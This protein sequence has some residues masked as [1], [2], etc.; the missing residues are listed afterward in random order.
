MTRWRMLS[1]GTLVVVGLAAMTLWLL[2]LWPRT[3]I[4]WILAPVMFS[5]V[6]SVGAPTRAPQDSTSD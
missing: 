4:D 6:L 5:P 2:G 3:P 1:L